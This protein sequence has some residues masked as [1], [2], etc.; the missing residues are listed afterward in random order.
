MISS[1]LSYEHID[2]N[3]SIIRTGIVSSGIYF[4]Y[5]GSVSV[6]Y[7]EIAH[8]LVIFEEGSYFGDISFIF[9][10][11][12]QY[13]YMCIPC[14]NSKYYSLQDKYLNEIFERFPEFRDVLQ[15]RALRR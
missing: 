2:E 3:K 8:A 6:Y 5:R 4:I 1:S 15:I 9:Q 7:K 12:N 10:V 14:N 13:N 11:I